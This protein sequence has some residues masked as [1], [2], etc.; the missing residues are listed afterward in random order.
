[1]TFKRGPISFEQEAATPAADP[2][3]GQFNT[4][5]IPDSQPGTRLGTLRDAIDRARAR[6][7]AKKQK[8]GQHSYT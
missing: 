5:E 8:P 4:S 3:P 1:M 7:L 6:E 2:Q